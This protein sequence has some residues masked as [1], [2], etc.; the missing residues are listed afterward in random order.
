MS[1]QIA[2]PQSFTEKLQSRMAG[3]AVLAVTLGLVAWVGVQAVR[4]F[5]DAWVAP[6]LLSPDND[7]VLQMRLAL[8]HQMAELQRAEAGIAG[9]DEDLVAVEAGINRLSELRH[10]ARQTLHWQ[11]G[12]QGDEQG[13]LVKAMATLNEQRTIVQRLLE[14]QQRLTERTREDLRGGLVDRT[15]MEAQEQALDA[16]QV[17]L[18]ENTRL[19]D[20]A[21]FRKTQLDRDGKALRTA[22]GK[23][24]GGSALMPEVA[25]GEEHEARLEIELLK[26]EAER[27][28][29][30]NARRVSMDAIATQRALLEEL[31]TR[32]LYRAMNESTQVAFVPYT[33]LNGI[34]E[35]DSVLSC[36]W[37]LFYCRS[38]GRVTQVLSGEVITPDPWGAIARGQYVLLNLTVPEAIREKVLRIRKAS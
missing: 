16:L 33:Q 4:A 1:G 5:T 26:L 34:R 27:R 9:I 14:R 17:Q 12:T 7:N 24:G 36:V 22:F 37:G 21:R 19:L 28:N 23:S 2:L 29:L 10:T 35:G 11:A 32:P 20:E 8:N 3:I 6:I 38:V 15:E 31:K 30:Q 13:A 25:A 18:I